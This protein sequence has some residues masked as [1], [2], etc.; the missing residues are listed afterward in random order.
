MKVYCDRDLNRIALTRRLRD[1]R[2]RIAAAL[3]MALWVLA[4]WLGLALSGA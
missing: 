4:I 3:L 2:D 1:R